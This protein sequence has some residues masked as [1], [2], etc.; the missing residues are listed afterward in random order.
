MQTDKKEEKKKRVYKKPRLRTIELAAEE[1]LGVGCK[2][3]TT[4][5]VNSD[6]CATLPCVG[7]DTS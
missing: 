5:G 6:F 2:T 4:G 1:V 7:L 3:A